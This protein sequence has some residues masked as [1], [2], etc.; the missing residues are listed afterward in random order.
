MFWID[1][2]KLCFLKMKMKFMI[3]IKSSIAPT[4]SLL[5]LNEIYMIGSVGNIWVYQ[6][7]LQYLW[8]WEILPIWYAIRGWRRQ[9]YNNF[10]S[11]GHGVVLEWWFLIDSF[12]YFFFFWKMYWFHFTIKCLMITKEV[13]TNGHSNPISRRRTS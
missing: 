4:F 9:L 1:L 13:D 7:F 3:N 10:I 8:L 11:Y 12:V 5:E 6:L 2:E